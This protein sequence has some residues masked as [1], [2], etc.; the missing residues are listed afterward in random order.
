MHT[1]PEKIGIVSELISYMENRTT[2]ALT[3]KN[4]DTTPHIA[5]LQGKIKTIGD[6]ATEQKSLEVQHQ[7]KTS[8]LKAATYNA[9]NDSSGMMDAMIGLLGKGTAA[10]NKLQTIR[11]RV[12]NH[13]AAASPAPASA[14]KP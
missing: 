8:D 5:R 7:N 11:S 12:R 2:T 10:A 3:A 9:Y 13:N 6:L 1:F 4:F 14:A